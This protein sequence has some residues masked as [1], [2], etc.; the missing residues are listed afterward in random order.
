ME[1]SACPGQTGGKIRAHTA[2]SG[3]IMLFNSISFLI[4]FPVVTLVY[5]LIPHKIRYLWHAVSY[6]HLDV[7]KRQFYP[8][9]FA[10]D[11]PNQ[12][13]Q[14]HFREF[15]SHHPVLHTLYLGICIG[16]GKQF[17]SY[18]LGVAIYTLSQM[19]VMSAI[20]AY[21]CSKLNRWGAPVWVWVLSILYFALH[22]L[23]SV[24]AVSTTKDVLF[25]GFLLLLIIFLY[26]M[27]RE[28][29]IFVHSIFLQARFLVTVIL[30]ASFRN[31]GLYAFLLCIPFI[32]MLQKKRR[33]RLT[34]I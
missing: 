24:F 10:Y 17:H 2:Q 32:L 29:D 26:E 5:F 8:G 18:N 15:T 30:M 20:F 3:G 19:A 16:I 21:T 23:N 13:S 1:P 28:P 12:V 4:F 27:F 7:Y 11:V 25:T 31:N 6:T 9:I 34:L 22:P 14:L 33:M